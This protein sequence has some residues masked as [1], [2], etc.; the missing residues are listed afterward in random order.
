MSCGECVRGL[1]GCERTWERQT[2]A[3]KN[4]ETKNDATKNIIQKM[5]TRKRW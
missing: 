3:L 4:D 1:G 5:V 2:M